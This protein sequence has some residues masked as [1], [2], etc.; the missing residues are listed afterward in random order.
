MGKLRLVHVVLVLPH[1]DGLR[2]DLHQLRQRVLQPA[3]DG[4][5][6]A[7][8]DVH[9][10]ELLGGQ[11]RCRVH[12]GAGLAD[13]HGDRLFSPGLANHVRHLT[14]KLGCLPRGGAV[15][16]GDELHVVLRHDGGELH[17]GLVPLVLWLVRV[18]DGGSQHLAGG[19]DGGALHAVTV[20]GVEPEHG[21]L[22]CRRG[23]QHVAEVDR[24][25][26]EGILLRFFAHPH[27]HV[28]RRRHLK[29]GLPRT[30]HGVVEPLGVRIA[31][32][33]K[34]HG[35]IERIVSPVQLHPQNAFLFPA[36]DGEHAV[37]GHVLSGL[38]KLEVV[39]VFGS[40]SF[41]AL[42]HSDDCRGFFGELVTQ[43]THEVGVDRQVRGQ[44]GARPVKHRFDVLVPLGDIPRR[45]FLRVCSWL[46]DDLLQRRAN[47]SLA[48]FIRFGFATLL[49]RQVQILEASLGIA[50]EDEGA[51]L[52]G[53]LSLFFDRREDRLLPVFQLAQVLQP[54]LEGA[55]LRVI[56]S[57][58]DLLA[59]A[60]DER[61]GVAFVEKLDRG[62]D[63]GNLNAEF[64][65][66]SCCNHL[67]N[68]S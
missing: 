50:L 10:W 13:D 28:E 2:I 29:L 48:G 56:Q 35:F 63:L 37:G 41:H 33:V 8:R 23:K 27:P 24:E 57:A 30:M 53:E 17:D 46:V 15:A 45:D 6:A 42:D 49:K 31:G 59:V 44:D 12:G 64:L 51:Q 47:S 67:P 61:D 40:V 68:C 4:H 7:Q 11:I 32:V 14:R 5:R 39:P 43:V 36:Q 1:A 18:H 19:I 9:V 66:D 60:G 52:I 16:N 3:G 25:N 62:F 58:G 55:K 22:P 34:H 54:P 20:A 21:F 38:G 65:S 26:G